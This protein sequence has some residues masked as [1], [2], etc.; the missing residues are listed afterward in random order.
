MGQACFD[1]VERAHLERARSGKQSHAQEGGQPFL[2]G[3]A[4]WT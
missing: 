4:T 1:D 3:S 2:L